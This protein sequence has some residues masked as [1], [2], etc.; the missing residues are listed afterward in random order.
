M[1]YA[2]LADIH[3]NLIAFQTVLQHI[4]EHGGVDEI[5]CLGDVVGYGPQPRECI[6]LLRQRKHVCVAG[7]HDLAAIAK[8]DIGDFN[9]NAAAA[10]RWTADQLDADSVAYL[11]SLPLTL[12]RSDFTLVHGSPRHPVWE[13][14][15]SESS[16]QENLGYFR[17]I[18]CLIGHSHMPLCFICSTD[19]SCS[20]SELGPETRLGDN[21]NRLIINPGGVGQPRDGDSRASYAIYDAE[22]GVLRHYRVPYDIVSV[23]QKMAEAG[24]PEHLA[25]RLSYGW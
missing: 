19:G 12:E 15:L 22:A 2:V 18:C 16:A 6:Q 7:N 23:Q 10:A 24:L 8:I 14:L 21:S 17:T 1:R 25:M 9:P 4:E 3:S 5:W 13:Y 20:I 11:D